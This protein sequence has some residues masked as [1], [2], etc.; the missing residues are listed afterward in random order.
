[1][2]NIRGRLNALEKETTQ[3]GGYTEFRVIRRDD[4]EPYSQ[5]QLEEIEQARR[6][7][8]QIQPKPRLYN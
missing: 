2:N 4:F 7:G 3:G 6:A 5:E 8:T 1:M